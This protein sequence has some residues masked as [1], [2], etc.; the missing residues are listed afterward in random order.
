MI[1]RT[2]AAARPG[3]CCLPLVCAALFLV[4]TSLGA[5][6]ATLPLPENLVAD[7]LP[8]IPVAIADATERYTNA[9]AAGF[10]DW[11]PT[12]REL[13][14][15]TRFANTVQVHQVAR[16][17]G[18]R[19]QLTFFD[20]PVGSARIDPRDG[21]FFIFA[22]DQ[23]GNEFQQ[24]YRFDFATGASTLLTDGGRSQNGGLAWSNRGD[25]LAYGS[26]RRN[27]ADRDIYVMDPRIPGSDRRVAE[28]D[29]GGWGVADW[30]PDDRT[31]LV[32]QSLSVTR[33]RLWTMDLESGRLALV[34]PRDTSDEV[35]HLNGRFSRD[36][37]R[38]WAISDR[39][40]EFRRLGWLDP[41][42]G[43]WTPVTS[44]LNWDVTTFDL[45]PD[46]RT[47]ALNTNA[48][49]V[50]KAYLYDIASTRLS[51]LPLPDGVIGGPRWHRKLPVLAFT[52]SNAR[53]P[54]DVWSYDVPAR[55]VTRWTESELGGMNPGQLQLQQLVEWPT[56]DGRSISGFYTRPPARF[57]G[58]RPVWI[59]IHGGPE[60]QARPGFLG[61]WN[62]LVN[63]L[64]VAFLQPN[65][66]GSTGF[67]KSFVALDNGPNREDS[68]RDI[69]ALLDWI[70]TRPEL[71]A[72]R[73][74]VSGGSYG[75]YMSLAVATMYPER[76]A[77]AVD[78]VGISNFITFLERTESY[79]RDLRR[80]EY[81]DERD[82][83]MRAVFERISPANKAD[84]IV[85]PLLV[86]QGA[87]DPRVPRHESDQMVAKVKANGTPVWYLLG[88]DEGHGFQKKA[89]SDYQFYAMVEFANRYLLAQPATP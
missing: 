17:M 35:V 88:T 5:Q 76:I 40:A 89:N 78:V 11:H 81:G 46:G 33:S 50:S 70:A 38:I 73:V 56:F 65:V 10:L 45:S 1:S 4:P 48:A 85:R 16:P 32:G 36:G 39:D 86:V 67:G 51:P 49:G 77:A 74:M 12:R 7:G 71:D 66:R 13:L 72:S 25:R 57:Q 64:G 44:A 23:G 21:A 31:L 30:S 6:A 52:L 68:V 37:K 84:R 80:V 18:A 62:Y 19:Q 83:A 69:G 87:N 27:G 47:I 9:R 54:S 61:R 53:S 29:G 26:T 42:T 59:E 22:R 8:P 63:E 28:V 58:P 82:P 3:R 43:A 24:L 2:R 14:V 79:R 60:G 55:K 75:G 20:E 15:S 34:A 41:A